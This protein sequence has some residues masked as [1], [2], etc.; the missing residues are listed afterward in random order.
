MTYLNPR[1]KYQTARDASTEMKRHLPAEFKTVNFA[2]RSAA[3][4][5]ISPRENCWKWFFALGNGGNLVPIFPV[6]DGIQSPLRHRELTKKSVGFKIRYQDRRVGR[7]L[8][9]F[10]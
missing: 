1:E 9:G 6:P 3:V 8:H 4:P 10:R 5:A 7:E 2:G